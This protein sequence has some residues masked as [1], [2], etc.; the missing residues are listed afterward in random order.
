MGLPNS[1]AY[2]YARDTFIL[3]VSINLCH[4]ENVIPFPFCTIFDHALKIGTV[5]VRAC[6]GSV[7]IIGDDEYAVPFGIFLTYAHLSFNGLFRLVFAGI[8]SI[9]NCDIILWTL[10]LTGKLKYT[11]GLGCDL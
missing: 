1:Y 4:N 2:F 8:T 5:V 6:H 3:R 11:N 10:F 7:D 9:D